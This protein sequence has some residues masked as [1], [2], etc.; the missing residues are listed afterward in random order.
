M[1]YFTGFYKRMRRVGFSKQSI[2]FS[3]IRFKSDDNLSLRINE[4]PVA[5]VSPNQLNLF[6]DADFEVEE[7]DDVDE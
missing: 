2:K 6:S 7:N 1:V 5:Y 4:D 3:Q